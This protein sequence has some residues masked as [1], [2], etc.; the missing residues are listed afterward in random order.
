MQ[1]IID[2]VTNRDEIYKA[3]LESEDCQ[4]IIGIASEDLGPGIF[5]T[6]ILEIIHEGN[7]Q[8]AILNSYDVTGHFLEKNKIPVRNI[9]SVISFRGVFVNPFLKHMHEVSDTKD[10]GEKQGPDYLF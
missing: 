10:S 2:L 6:F 4:T 8:I 5:M 7:E 1:N 3:L 9:T